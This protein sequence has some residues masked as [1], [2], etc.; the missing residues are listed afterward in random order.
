[1]NTVSFLNLPTLLTLFR[2][3]FSPFILPILLVTFLP[4][5]NF[6]INVSL[7]MVFSLLSLTD[8]LDGY[9]AR[10]FS[11]ETELGKVLDPIADKFLMYAT[12]ISLL[13]VHKIYYYW[14][15]LLIGREFFIMGLRL[16]AVQNNFTI[17][18]SFYGKLKTMVQFFYFAFAI[19]N[20]AL[21]HA[22]LEMPFFLIQSCLLASTLLLSCGSAYMYYQEFIKMIKIRVYE[23][24][25]R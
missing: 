12:L 2:L 17:A 20:P 1:M 21:L 6:A 10:K 22:A 24:D 7:T 11:Q 19:L 4:Y 18:V 9:M 25:F 14:V 15:I 13:A 3:V 8:L 5:N 23:G 16:I